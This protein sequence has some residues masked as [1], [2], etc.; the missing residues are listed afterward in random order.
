MHFADGFAHVSFI[1]YFARLRLF[2]QPFDFTPERANGLKERT[3]HLSAVLNLF[4]RGNHGH[5]NTHLAQR[6][7]RFTQSIEHHL[8][9]PN[10]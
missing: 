6:I 4:F 9:R 10:L 7:S 8:T 2:C 3:Q 5:S 1:G